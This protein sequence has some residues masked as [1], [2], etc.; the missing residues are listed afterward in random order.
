M[1]NRILTDFKKLYF[2]NFELQSL[3]AMR[4][5]WSDGHIIKMSTPRKTTGLLFLNECR[6]LYTV[7]NG[8]NFLADKK[9]VVCLPQGST[10]TC[11]NFNCG[12]TL[13][14]ALLVEFNAT[15]GENLL[16]FGDAPFVIKDVNIPIAK[17][18]FDVSVTAYKASAFSPLEMKTAVYRLLQHLCKENFN[19]LHSRLSCIQAGIEIIENNPLLD[20]SIEEIAG[21]CNVTSCYFRRLF[22]E[23][24]GKSPSQY[25]I[26]LKLNIAKRML[27]GGESNLEY[28]AETLNFESASYLC[29]IFKKHFGITPGQYRN[30]VHIEIQ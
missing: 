10:Y 15:D 18:L 30:S 28:I 21:A 23:Y 22:K 26:D 13:Q 25:R 9:S 24:S 11:E 16:S 6:G 3:F 29:R 1:K 19:K 20:I 14:D 12:N 5:K 8:Q 17:E 2:S 7:K 4:Q 27:Q